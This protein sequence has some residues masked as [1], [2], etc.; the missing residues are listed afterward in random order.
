MSK[1]MQPL[2]LIQRVNAYTARCKE[3]EENLKRY[4]KYLAEEH[5]ECARAFR[6][7]LG[8]LA[9]HLEWPD[10]LQAEIAAPEAETDA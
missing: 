10:W 1:K 5:R 7:S 8:P 2:D 6:K 4:P 9:D 3:T